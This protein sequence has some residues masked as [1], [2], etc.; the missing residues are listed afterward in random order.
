MG[1]CALPETP[2]TQRQ[3]KGVARGVPDDAKAGR[4]LPQQRFV[5]PCSGGEYYYTNDHYASFRRIRE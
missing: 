1:G 5:A 2:G 3:N 4:N